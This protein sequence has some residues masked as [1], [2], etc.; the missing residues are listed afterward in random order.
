M[1]LI[2]LDMPQT[3]GHANMKYLHGSNKQSLPKCSGEMLSCEVISVV[4]PWVLI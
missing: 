3:E 2:N 4:S 1:Y